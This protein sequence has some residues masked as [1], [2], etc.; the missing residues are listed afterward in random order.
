M[1]KSTLEMLKELTEANG[2]S[3]FEGEIREMVK[4]HLGDMTAISYDGLG[5]IICEKRGTSPDPKIMIPGHMDEIGFMV[6]LIDKEGFIR[7]APLGG[8]FDQTLLAKQVVILTDKGPVVGVIGSKPPHILPAEERG[9]VIAKKSMFIDVGATSKKQAEKE[10]GIRIGNPIVPRAGFEVMKNPKLLMSKAW[11]DRVGVGLFIDVI[12]ALAGEKHPNSVFGVGT[13]QEEV[14]TRGAETSA[15]VV[16]PDVCIVLDVGI[17]ADMP[18]ISPEEAQGKMGDGPVLYALDAG[19][20]AHHRFHDFMVKLAEKEKIPYQLSV[21]EGGATD[22]R[23]IQLHQRGVPTVN[24]AI[25]TR[26]I[27]SHWGIIH[28]DDYDATLK[29]LLAAIR[30]LDRKTVASLTD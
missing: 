11:D 10:F 23:A 5:S 28:V 14:G 20:I 2:V 19:S 3:G 22:G 18:G 25:A 13:V 15:D 30:K 24:V 21:M 4:R 9:K 27:H 17:A 29:L 7:F 12:K 8:W 6:K 26:Y 1:K 16:N